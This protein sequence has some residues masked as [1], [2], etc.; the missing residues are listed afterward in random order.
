MSSD[1]PVTVVSR[2]Y[3]SS[4]RRTWKCGLVSQ[5]TGLLVFVGVFNDTIFHS[6]LGQISKGTVSFEYYWLE[7]WYNV[8]C[9]HEPDGRLRNFYCNI[10]MPPKFDGKTLDYVDLD[11]DLIV[12][13]DGRIK[14]LDE[15]DF[16]ANSAMYRY[17]G[18][19]VECAHSAVE[20]LKRLIESREFPFGT[21]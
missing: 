3:D 1:Q 4:V 6:H 18:E 14:T 7:R 19:V 16:T 9:F 8:F 20:E 11:I 21:L 17:P 2:K 13:P 15:D 10:S 5:K 12:W